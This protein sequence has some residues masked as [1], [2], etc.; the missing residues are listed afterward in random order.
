M[1]PFLVIAGLILLISII[2]LISPRFRKWAAMRKQAKAEYVS[3]R[4]FHH[5]KLLKSAV[6][7]RSIQIA[8]LQN[9]KANWEKKLKSTQVEFQNDLSQALVKYI[10]KNKLS[11]VPGIGSVLSDRIY[12]QVYQGKLSDFRNASNVNGV[13]QEK[14][15]AIDR[16][17]TKYE[18]ALP[19]LIQKDFPGKRKIEEEYHARIQGIDGQISSNKIVLNNLLVLRDKAN[20]EL[21]WLEKVKPSD[22]VPGEQTKSSAIER[23]SQFSAGVF[24]EW[25][26][27]P[28]WFSEFISVGNLQI[29]VTP[30][31]NI[32]HRINN[33]DHP[34]YN[35]KIEE[36]FAEIKEFDKPSQGDTYLL[37]EVKDEQTKKY[38]NFLKV[39]FV[40]LGGLLFVCCIGTICI[41]AIPDKWKEGAATETPLGTTVEL[42]TPVIFPQETSTRSI[43]ATN[44]PTIIKSPT[45]ENPTPTP[46]IV[47]AVQTHTPSPT[48]T[49]TVTP[50]ER[51][52]GT[53]VAL[54]LNVRS[55][56]DHAS[57]LLGYLETDEKVEVLFRDETGDWMFV[58]AKRL[59]LT[60]WVSANYIELEGDISEIE[61]STTVLTITPQP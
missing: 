3:A 47:P 50:Q 34:A 5:L 2:I 57:T 1:N 52:Y 31:K 59:S 28:V 10:A 45:R 12:Y 13:G 36:D 42:S 25:E 54:F 24:P 35:K 49:N 33:N 27:L 6:K 21:A 58:E 38:K 55:A 48:P 4:G 40:F 18:N 30:E 11:E 46:S 16:W 32:P 53:V 8:Q 9:E 26:D 60:G 20:K 22:F 19:S 15:W 29:E 7:Q 17:V 39:L 14:Q 43:T 61:I 41:S 23:I 51:H 56:P 44:T 37:E